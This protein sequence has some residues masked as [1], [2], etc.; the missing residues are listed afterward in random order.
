MKRALVVTLPEKGHYHPLLGPAEALARGGVEVSFCANHDIRAELLAA[1]VER[2]VLPP[3]A[4]PPVEGLRGEALARVL[5]DPEALRGWIHLLLVET[6]A[7]YVEGLRAVLRQLRPDVVALDTMAYDAAIAAQ[8]EGIPWVGWATSLNPV[9]PES[10]DSELSRTLRA[11]D[12]QRHALFARFGLSAR[13]RVS[14]VL[15][16]LGTACFST[17]AL[18]G[19][20]PEGVHLV[21]PSRGGTRAGAAV[22]LSFARGRPL[23]Y[24][25]FGSQAWYQ[26]AR[27]ARVFEAA[28]ALGFAVLAAAGDLAAQLTERGLP[29][30]VRCVGFAPQL[31]VLPRAAVLV[32]HGGANSVMEAL[33]AGVPLL[34][35]P[36]CNDQPHNAH[37]VERAGAGVALDLERC[38]RAQLL[39]ALGRLAADGPERAAC[40]R[41]QASYAAHD[42]SEGAAALAREAL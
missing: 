29:E 2:V 40:R 30:H 10:M 14:D 27:Y 17:E 20:A 25:S 41:V 8:L 28:G 36:L 26:P 37:Y 15:S 34:V 9:V 5:A 38:T 13:F 23:V 32:T 31:E 24:V 12:P 1:G 7:R 3:G 21:G 11:L 19:P 35:A 4:Q 39:S 16:P 33:A 18:V 22:D 42:G 6:P